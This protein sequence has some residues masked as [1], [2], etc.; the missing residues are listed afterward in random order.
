MRQAVVV[1]ASVVALVAVAI[2]P[3]IYLESRH[4]Q[5]GY[6]SHET[7]R[8]GASH[9]ESSAS[10]TPAT[11]NTPQRKP[12]AEGDPNKSDEPMKLTDLL[13]VFVGFLQFGAIVGQIFIYRRQAKIMGQQLASMRIASRTAHRVAEA[14]PRVER[15]YVSILVDAFY[16]TVHQIAPGRPNAQRFPGGPPNWLQVLINN[17]GKTP[18]EVIDIRI[19]IRGGD[20]PEIPPDFTIEEAKYCNFWIKSDLTSHALKYIPVP[21]EFKEPFVFGRVDYR[22]ILLKKLHSSGFI[23]KITQNDG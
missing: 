11:A 7:D 15:A 8:P 10:P 18:G 23:M 21:G 4:Y 6:T 17:L 16:G 2:A 5:K 14:L 3:D 20:I 1:L 12:L 13:L 22:D 9:A 19:S